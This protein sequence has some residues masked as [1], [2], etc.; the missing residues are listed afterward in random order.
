MKIKCRPNTKGKKLK[1][2]E[3]IC[4]K[5]TEVSNILPT[6]NGFAIFTTDQHHADS[7]FQPETRPQ[8]EA[9]CY[10]AIMPPELR[11]KKSII[12]PRADEIIYKK[13]TEARREEIL[14]HNYWIGEENDIEIYKFPRTSTIKL[15]FTQTILAE[16]C[17]H[18]GVKAFGMSQHTITPD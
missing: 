1:L 18:T 6:F 4:S 5:D 11:V 2:L 9:H 16:K 7:I 14:R 10:T 17:L 8:L 13:N 3:I 15:T 12:I